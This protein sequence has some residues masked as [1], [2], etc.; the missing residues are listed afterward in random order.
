[1]EIPAINSVRQ[2]PRVILELHEGTDPAHPQISIRHENMPQGY[3]TV[4][5]ILHA[6]LGAVLPQAFTQL[7]QQQQG[8]QPR[9]VIAHGMN[10][11]RH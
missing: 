3:V 4:V 2:T 5:Q 11:L 8:Q 9:I 6:A 1:M 10:D 7:L